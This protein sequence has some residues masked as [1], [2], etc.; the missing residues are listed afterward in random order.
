MYICI[1]ICLYIHI[2]YILLFPF[3]GQKGTFIHFIS[4]G[5]FPKSHMDDNI[6]VKV[7]LYLLSQGHFDMME[8]LNYRS[9]SHCKMTTQSPGPL[10]PPIKPFPILMSSWMSSKCQL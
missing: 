6:G 4:I 5:F 8:G 1:Y 3:R 2:F 7:G 9:S 10:L